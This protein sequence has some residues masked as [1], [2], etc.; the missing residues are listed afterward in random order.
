M[1][2]RVQPGGTPAQ[3]RDGSVPLLDLLLVLYLQPVG[4]WWDLGARLARPQTA[5]STSSFLDIIRVSCASSRL[6]NLL[7]NPVT[8]TKTFP[9]SPALCR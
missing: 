4:K 2:R 3:C 5:L 1:G 8:H 7:E 9:L 6:P